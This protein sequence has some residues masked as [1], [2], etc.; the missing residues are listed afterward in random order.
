MSHCIVRR[1]FEARDKISTEQVKK[2]WEMFPFFLL[3]ISSTCV[4][5]V[6]IVSENL[7]G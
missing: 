6:R 1:G 4:Q 3:G 5:Q 7:K 2:G